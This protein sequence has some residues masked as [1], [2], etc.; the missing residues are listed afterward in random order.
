MIDREATG[1]ID[2]DQAAD[3][4]VARDASTELIERCTRSYIDR[5]TVRH[6]L[7]T[8]ARGPV[9]EQRLADSRRRRS[10]CRVI[11]IE[12]RAH[13]RR[14][15]D[16]AYPFSGK[17]A[18]RDR[19]DDVT[20]RIE[21]YGADR[22]AARGSRV[23]ASFL[24]ALSRALADQV[25]RR[26]LGDAGETS[27]RVRCIADQEASEFSVSRQGFR[28]SHRSR[29]ATH[30]RNSTEATRRTVHETRVETHAAVFGQHRAAAGVERRV[31]FHERDSGDHRGARADL[32][33]DD[34]AC[35]SFG[36]G[37]RVRGRILGPRDAPGS[38]V[39]DQYG[40]CARGQDRLAARVPTCVARRDLTDSASSSSTGNVISHDM[41]ASVTLWP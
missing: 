32:E 30:S 22:V 14:V 2:D 19:R 28:D 37:I 39:D 20:V 5:E 26:N 7:Q 33:L 10:A 36:D 6:Q 16:P 3:S 8:A 41:H 13:D 29:R 27:G 18:R 4:D 17:S 12:A 1:T 31:L 24:L 23:S 35:E 25:F 15:P 40:L 11:G 34:A 9:P 38:A 21:R